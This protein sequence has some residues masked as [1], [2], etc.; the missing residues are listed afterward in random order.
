MRLLLSALLLSCL[1]MPALSQAPNISLFDTGKKKTLTEDE[2]K[3]Q[4]ER[5]ND[6]KSAVGKIP[7]RKVTTDP[8]G[9]VRATAPAQT[10]QKPPR[11]S[12]K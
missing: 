5:E 4:A 2:L 10:K 8:W 1:T 9:N 7:D 11:E 6:Y 3:A 12:A